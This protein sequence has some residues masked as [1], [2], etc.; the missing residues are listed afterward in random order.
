MTRWRWV[1]FASLVIP[2]WGL[3]ALW[4]VPPAHQRAYQVFEHSPRRNVGTFYGEEIRSTGLCVEIWR[5]GRVDTIV[6]GRVIV[7]ETVSS[8]LGVP[9][10]S[11]RRARA[12]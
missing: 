11:E 8:M 12:Q 5:R 10:P 1:A 6:C 2:L 4:L 3:L 7:T 9:D